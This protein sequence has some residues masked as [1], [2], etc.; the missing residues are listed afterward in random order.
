MKT[1]VFKRILLP[2]IALCFFVIP[3]AGLSEASVDTSTSTQETA[4][5]QEVEQQSSDK[6]SEK[7]KLVKAEAMAVLEESQKA[8]KALEAKETAAAIASLEKVTGKLQILL[9]RDPSMALAPVNVE[10]MTYDLLASP[11][12]VKAMIYDAENALEDGD[13]PKA[14]RLVSN[15]ASEIQYR[16]LNIPLATYPQAIKAVIPLIDD[17]KIE[18]A[19]ESLQLALNTLVVTTD[20]IIPLPKLRAEH[21]LKNAEALAETKDRTQKDNQTLTE[22]LQRAREQ[23]E[24]AELLGYGKKDSFESLHEQLKLLEEKTSGGKSGI[25]WFD[26][27]KRQVSDIF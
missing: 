6:I 22:L 21:Y 16:A 18:E 5:Q 17:G 26:K 24:I 23:L 8:L 13:I 1:F 27:I 25:G 10:V 11:D 9:A 2:F 3:S 4:V 19:R 12:A 7:R 20:E 14:R 15:L